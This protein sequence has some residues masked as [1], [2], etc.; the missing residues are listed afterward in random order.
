LVAVFRDEHDVRNV[1]VVSH[2]DLFERS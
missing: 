2:G 1:F